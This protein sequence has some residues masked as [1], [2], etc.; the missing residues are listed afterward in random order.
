MRPQVIRRSESAVAV[1]SLACSPR[2]GRPSA[3]PARR[4]RCGSA[5]GV[6]AGQR[7]AAR[8]GSPAMG[9]DRCAVDSHGSPWD[10]VSKRRGRPLDGLGRPG[11]C[12]TR[13]PAPPPPRVRG[14]GEAGVGSSR[15]GLRR[16]PWTMSMNSRSGLPALET[17]DKPVRERRPAACN[18]L[19]RRRR[20]PRDGVSAGE[21]PHRNSPVCAFMPPGTPARRRAWPPLPVP[22]RLGR[23]K[24]G[25]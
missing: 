10:R 1:C 23:G 21:N 6:S 13:G 3:G 20:P 17:G 25:A 22:G 7:G 12:G 16:D 2:V 8:D 9:A 24:A 11:S 5:V 4:K 18:D 14:R 15:G 19:S